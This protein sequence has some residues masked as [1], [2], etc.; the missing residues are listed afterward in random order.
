MCWLYQAGSGICLSNEK[1]L[2]NLLEGT[3]ASNVESIALD[4]KDE[5]EDSNHV[6]SA[7]K[8]F[9]FRVC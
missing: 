4:E 3:A 7:S 1:I 2:R 5:V 9:Y 8:P 6:T